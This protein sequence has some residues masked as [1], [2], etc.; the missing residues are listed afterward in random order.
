MW[1]STLQVPHVFLLL[2]FSCT[3]TPCFSLLVMHSVLLGSPESVLYIINILNKACHID[4]E[5]PR[6][7][8]FFLLVVI[9]IQTISNCFGA[10][11]R[12]TLTVFGGP[13]GVHS[14]KRL[15]DEF[16][17]VSV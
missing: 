2:W 5:R 17:S 12:V 10:D 6:M 13:P 1:N 16:L 11:T 4:L 9:R 14:I 15:T 7:W 8:V 3:F